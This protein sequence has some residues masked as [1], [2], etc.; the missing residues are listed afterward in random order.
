MGFSTRGN[1]SDL[2]LQELKIWDRSVGTTRIC[3]LYIC[4]ADLFTMPMRPYL[5]DFSNVKLCRF[6][7]RYKFIETAMT[8]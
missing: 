8:E 2:K 4:H 7:I 1:N 5:E 6:N 3:G